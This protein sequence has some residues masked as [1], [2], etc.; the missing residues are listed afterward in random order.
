MGLN[1]NEVMEIMKAFEESC[2]D[3]LKLEVEGLKLTLGK[4]AGA[5]DNPDTVGCKTEGEMAGQQGR[6]DIGIPAAPSAGEFHEGA[7]MAGDSAK[8][9][10]LAVKAPLMGIFYR[11]P[12][13]GAPPFV[14]IG[15]HV[16]EDTN[17]CIIEVM[18]LFTGVK[19]GVTGR[20]VEICAEN[21]QLVEYQQRLFLVD[22]SEGS[23]DSPEA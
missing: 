16:T 14:S 11:S 15:T 21:G 7:R 9:G 2:F 12:K 10:L 5:R 17:T 3:E 8:T 22:P 19:A 6:G 4:G 20:I 23:K 18:K 1:E 13:P